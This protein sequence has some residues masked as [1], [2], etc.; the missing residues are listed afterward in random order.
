MQ[1]LLIKTLINSVALYLVSYIFPA[2]TINNPWTALLAGFVLSILAV[3]I[4][5]I[6]LVLALPLSLLSFGLFILVINAW[7]LQ[8]TDLMVKGLYI[9]GFWIAL[10]A[11][12]VIM[13]L[14]HLVKE[15]PDMHI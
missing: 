14:N 12:L 2:V 11:S 9:P 1:K 7:M 4:R 15:S 3:T 10:L 13:V 6:L 8:L 5:P